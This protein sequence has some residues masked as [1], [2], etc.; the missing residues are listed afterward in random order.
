MTHRARTTSG[1]PNRSTR[2]AKPTPPEE[3]VCGPLD[4]ACAS[5]K[6]ESIKL[7]RWPRCEAASRQPHGKHDTYLSR[8]GVLLC[9]A[10]GRTWVE[11]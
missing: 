10:C 11:A 1:T 8:G 4:A 6:C 3:C 7:Y 2:R 5:P 9:R